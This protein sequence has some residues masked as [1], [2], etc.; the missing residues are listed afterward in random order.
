MTNLTKIWALHISFALG[1]AL[2]ALFAF[3]IY[4]HQVLPQNVA[5][6]GMILLLDVI[7]LILVY[8]AG[9]E[10]PRIQWGWVT[11]AICIFAAIIFSENTLQWGWVETISL[12]CCIASIALWQIK[13]AKWGLWPYMAAM[14]ISFIP[15][16]VEYFEKPQP[17][18]WWLW[19]GS[20]LACLFAIY[21]AKKYD[22]ANLFIPF[23]AFVLNL[24]ILILVMR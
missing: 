18:T 24:L 3:Q 7:G 20:M 16:G 22:F 19:F 8:K 4:T 17:E 21:G 1:F 2:P 13:N 14:Y 10:D 5:T 15:Q 12:I 9:N 23:G 11:A 6:W